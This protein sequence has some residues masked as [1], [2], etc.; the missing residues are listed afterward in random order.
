VGE[1]VSAL[2]PTRPA[3]R[4]AALAL[5]LTLLPALASALLLAHA[6]RHGVGIPPDSVVYLE[7]SR[8]L[9][10]GHGITTGGEGPGLRPLTRFPPLYPV[11]I[12]AVSRLGLDSLDAARWLQLAL[13]VANVGLVGLLVARSAPGAR[14]LPAIGAVLIASSP[15][16]LVLHG[17]ALSEPLFFLLGFSGLLVLSLHLEGPR[18]PLLLAASL[19]VGLA[20]LTRYVG[21]ALIATGVL[22]ILLAPGI[23]LHHRLRDAAV[24]AGVGLLPVSIWGLRNWLTGGSATGR[25][26][27]F[28][29]ISADAIS[30]A[31]DSAGEWLL[32]SRV[33][34]AA[35]GLL[36]A[37][38]LLCTLHWL[39]SGGARGAPL[40][41]ILALLV[42]IY[43]LALVASISWLDAATPLGGRILS[44]ALIAMLVLA[45]CAVGA[46]ARARRSFAMAAVLLALVLAAGYASTS[47]QWARERAALGG[48]GFG[49]L[50]W[51][52][53]PTIRRV[54]ELPAGLRVYSNARDAILILTGR[55]SLW[56][57]AP[58]DAETRRP[59]PGYTAELEQIRSGLRAKDT[60]LVWF[61]GVFWRWYLPSG[62]DLAA[63]LPIR[64]ESR[65]ADGEIWSYDAGRDLER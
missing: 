11:A 9:A 21:A 23:R 18:A 56:L 55:P 63:R 57:P 16:I 12:A 47:M 37:G 7:A 40:A 4:A 41:R 15:E 65:F 33:G 42:P 60:A 53:S 3:R 51:R 28:H 45:L 29:P 49:S 31:A 6:T 32:A 58:L 13:L 1:S 5:I 64:C 19:A 10:A 34:G 24:L 8:N 62:T 20:V 14:W 48:T 36:A 50:A 38:L 52:S 26:F 17:A 46:Q 61:D 35:A 22:A 2:S 54:A 59:R 30:L 44:P 39:V 25:S 27:A 43:A